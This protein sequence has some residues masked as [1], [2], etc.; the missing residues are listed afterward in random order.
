MTYGSLF[1]GIGGFDLG[2][3]RAGMTCKWQVEINEFCRRVL[4]KHWPDVRRHDDV[5]TF[6]PTAADEW[7][8]DVNCGGFPCQDISSSGNKEGIGG[9]RS[10][11][12][13]EYARIVR[14][15]RP[16]FVVVE[17]VADVLHRGLGTVLRDLAGMGFDAEWRCLPAAAFGVPQRRPRVFVIADSHCRGQQGGE[18]RD[19]LGAE[20]ERRDYLDGL[21]VAERAAATAAARVRR[22]GGR[23][24][25]GVDRHR[26]AACGNAVVPQVAQWIGRRLMEANRCS[27]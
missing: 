23:V 24:P 6:P 22:M 10:G 2:F 7:R 5:K 17:N 25:G 20:A 13:S 8:V 19:R 26:I 27:P 18:K 15:L 14:L 3:E 11:L 12:W 16:R 9:E 1:A 4:A 21:A